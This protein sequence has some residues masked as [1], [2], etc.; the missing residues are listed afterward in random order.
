MTAPGTIKSYF[1]SSFP[2][3]AAVYQNLR[4]SLTS[5]PSLESVFREIY[6]NNTWK[7][8]ESVS[9]RGS[10]LLRTEVI[11]RSLPPLLREIG[12]RTLLDAA[13]GDF[14]W[15]QH[16]ALEDIK[17][18]GIDIVPELVDSNRSRY[19]NAQ[20]KFLTRDV[21]K[22]RL[23]QADAILCRDCL[24][25]LSFAR[26]NRTISNFKRN[27]AKYLLCTTHNSIVQNID[28]PDG[29]WRSINLQIDPFNFPTP[30]RLIVEDEEAGKCLG[31]W[32]V[33]E[34]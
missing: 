8:S 27:R 7:N 5:G 34:L 11:M 33:D 4:R 18:I 17:Y 25:H 24:I 9:G 6:H 26:I 28:C 20:R 10:T 2:R 31:L 3:A 13:C 32:R 22:N 14:N 23:P 15:M 30:I 12:V 29:D 21:S 19:A 1:T 16:T